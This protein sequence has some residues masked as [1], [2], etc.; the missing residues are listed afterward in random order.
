[1]S[2]VG[3]FGWKAPE[4]ITQK[5]KTKSVDIFSLGCTFYYL[6]TNGKHPFGEMNDREHNIL[7]G[8]YNLKDLKSYE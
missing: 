2:E 3:S 6:L 7:N 4:M 1:L 8:S 5:E